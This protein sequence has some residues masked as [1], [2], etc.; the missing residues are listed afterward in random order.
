MYD[1]RRTCVFAH[2]A[3]S[4]N[5]IEKSTHRV[6]I[7]ILFHNIIWYI[8]IIHHHVPMRLITKPIRLLF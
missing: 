5:F 2:N 4:I 7:S 8:I 6:K 1:G 3:H